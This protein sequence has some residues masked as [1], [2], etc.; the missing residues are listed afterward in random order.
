MTQVQFRPTLLWKLTGWF[1]INPIL[2]A[3]HGVVVWIKKRE[4]LYKLLVFNYGESQAFSLV[5]AVRSE[6]TKN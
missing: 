4:E 3:F 2:S 5:E 1:W 6:V